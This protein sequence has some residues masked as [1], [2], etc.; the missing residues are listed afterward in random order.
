MNITVFMQSQYP[1]IMQKLL[2]EHFKESSNEQEGEKV[3]L[4]NCCCIFNFTFDYKLE[5]LENKKCL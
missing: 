1:H 2:K 3:H 4:E 5:Y